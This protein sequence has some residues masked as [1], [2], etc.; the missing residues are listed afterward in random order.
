[1]G[2]S[3]SN[4]G[5]R[6]RASQLLPGSADQWRLRRHDGRAEAALIALYGLRQLGG[7]AAVSA[8]VFTFS[9]LQ[10]PEDPS[11]LSYKADRV[12]LKIYLSRQSTNRR[13]SGNWPGI[14]P[15]TRTRARLGSRRL[16]RKPPLLF[17]SLLERDFV[18]YGI[19]KICVTCIEIGQS[20]QPA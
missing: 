16:C 5:C 15:K 20:A 8:D 3:R 19:F 18:V 12:R 1:M 10:A 17:A 2:V 9:V 4:D 7:T 11:P 6:A 14:R 13:R